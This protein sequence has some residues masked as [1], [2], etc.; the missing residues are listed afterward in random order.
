MQLRLVL[1][2]QRTGQHRL[3]G[4]LRTR[5]I[6]TGADPGAQLEQEQLFVKGAANLLAQL[7]P[8][9]YRAQ[10]WQSYMP[11]DASMVD[12]STK[13]LRDVRSLRH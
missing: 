6:A 5:T 7:E 4:S 12:V 9:A 8:R 11:L 13:S 3:S 2:E 1:L 10:W